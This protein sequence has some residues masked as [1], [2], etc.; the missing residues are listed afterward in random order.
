[1]LNVI[2]F[3]SSQSKENSAILRRNFTEVALTKKK[4]I[5][6]YRKLFILFLV[7]TILYR[8]H[9]LKLETEVVIT[10]NSNPGLD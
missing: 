7:L 9:V 4:N 2:G 6:R 5:G 8:Y 1:M 3:V 10:D